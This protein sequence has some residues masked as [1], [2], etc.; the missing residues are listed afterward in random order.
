MTRLTTSSKFVSYTYTATLRR[1]KLSG[2]REREG[3]RKV[4]GG[5][6]AGREAYRE[7]QK[8]G[9]KLSKIFYIREILNKMSQTGGGGGGPKDRRPPPPFARL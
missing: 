1:C 4:R 7:T 8:G 9:R 2:G 5:R 3:D 6:E